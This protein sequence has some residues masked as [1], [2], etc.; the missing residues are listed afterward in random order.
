MG[1]SIFPLLAMI[2]LGGCGH[3]R[4][5]T[6]SL[7]GS[8]DAQSYVDFNA[9]MRDKSAVV[10]GKDGRRRE[11]DNLRLAFD[12]VG[13]S[14]PG[15]GRRL[16]MRVLEVDRFE[17][18]ERGASG[19]GG[20]LIGALG[21]AV[22]GIF[23]GEAVKGKDNDDNGFIVPLVMGGGAAL[24]GATGLVIGLVGGTVH[25]FVLLPDSTQLPSPPSPPRGNE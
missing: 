16:N 1:R 9:S 10:V 7:R 8:G 18:T 15:S 6:V 2:L 19:A 21:G 25:S 12:S 17:T 20:F 14:D 24:G 4:T 22:L 23:V 11:A 3:T 5:S 13:W